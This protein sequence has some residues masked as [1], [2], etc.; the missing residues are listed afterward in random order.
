ML[1]SRRLAAALVPRSLAA[2]QG[3]VHCSAAIRSLCSV[4]SGSGAAASAGLRFGSG[5][6]L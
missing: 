2:L 3:R 1:A 5:N 4:T 6:W